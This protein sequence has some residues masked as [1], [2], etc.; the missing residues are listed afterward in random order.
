MLA[1]RVLRATCCLLPAPT[2]PLTGTVSDPKRG[3]VIRIDLDPSTMSRFEAVNRLWD[4][5]A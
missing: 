4:I 3:D 1:A 5:I 2:L